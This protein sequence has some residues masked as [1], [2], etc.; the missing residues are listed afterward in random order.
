MESGE[1]T[2]RT[3][4]LAGNGAAPSKSG[5]SSAPVTQERPA[6]KERLRISE[7]GPQ[8]LRPVAPVRELAKRPEPIAKPASS[9]VQK[10]LFVARTVLPLVQKA[11][12]LLD[13]NVA[14]V[15]ANLLAP[16]FAGPPTDL[17]PLEA[18]VAKLR[19][20][21]TSLQTRADEQAAALKRMEEQVE[22]A[23]DAA[24]RSALE[25]KELAVE[26]EAL[27]RKLTRIAWVGGGL[28]AI[29]LAGNAFL[30]LRIAEI[31]R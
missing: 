28:L 1:R 22:A 12:P 19:A 30:L 8:P 3:E 6:E 18:A 10:A 16:T 7:A 2:I 11:L 5:E 26:V 31:L 27:R 9:A 14:A 25:A 15:I 20:E 13:G 23:K 17:K 21:R 29:L 4:A 24:E